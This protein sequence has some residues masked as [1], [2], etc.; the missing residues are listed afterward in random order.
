MPNS[1]PIRI[2][3]DPVPPSPEK[4]AESRMIAPKSAIEPAATTSCPSA[5]PT[6]SPSAVSMVRPLRRRSSDAMYER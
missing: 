6:P 4:N 5:T 3:V 2:S 1:E